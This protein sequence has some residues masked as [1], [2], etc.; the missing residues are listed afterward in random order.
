MKNINKLCFVFVFMI[1]LFSF[2]MKVDAAQELTCLYEKELTHSKILLIQYSDGSRVIFTNKDN[3]G[4][5]GTGWFRTDFNTDNFG[6]DVV[7]TNGSLTSCP[8][9]VNTI[10]SENIKFYNDVSFFSISEWTGKKIEDGGIFD[11]VKEPAYSSVVKSNL[12]NDLSVEETCS[13]DYWLVN[14]LDNSK[15]TASCLYRYL[16]D[17]NTCHLVQVNFGSRE[18]QITEYDSRKGFEFSGM[19]SY[20]DVISNDMYFTKQMSGNFRIN[21]DFSAN[22]LLDVTNGTC[23][24]AIKV[25]RNAGN[26]SSETLTDLYTETEVSL[27]GKGNTYYLVNTKGNN[28]ITN[29]EL[30][31]DRI[32]NIEIMKTEIDSCEDLFGEEIAGIFKSAWNFVKIFIPILLFGL[33]CLD[34]AKAIFAGKEEDMKKAQSKFIKRIIIAVV[35]FLVPVI[36]GFLLNIANGIWGNIGS[37]ICGILS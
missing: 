15:Y 29:E 27:K 13:S 21:K 22:S 5:D 8:N 34:F 24:N 30:T 14:E 37:D 20:V 28:P 10:D 32:S 2:N 17:D 26:L 23:I 25:K 35:I 6:D 7:L 33:G 3:A 18:L 9:Y 36:L 16:L 1:T 4:I 11:V 12:S 19:Y 31:M